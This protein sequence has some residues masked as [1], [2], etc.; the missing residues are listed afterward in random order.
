[1]SLFCV[2]EEREGREERGGKRG[3]NEKERK[4]GKIPRRSIRDTGLHKPINGRSGMGEKKSLCVFGGIV[5]GVV[6]EWSG[7][8]RCQCE[9]MN[10]YKMSRVC[11][12]MWS[13]VWC[14]TVGVQQTIGFWCEYMGNRLQSRKLQSRK[15][16]LYNPRIC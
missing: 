15:E 14:V 12:E 16:Q 1:M 2:R 9:L 10:L 8:G 5:G 6:V 11:Y 7:I 13:F 4:S 3:G